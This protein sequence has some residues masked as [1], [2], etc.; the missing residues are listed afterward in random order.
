LFGVCLFSVRLLVGLIGAERARRRGI[1]AAPS[2]VVHMVS[3]LS[4]RLRIRRPVRVVVSALADAPALIGWLRTVILL[5]FSTLN[6]LTP[7]QLEA[8][9]TH[10]LAHIRRHDYLVNLLQTVVETV[11]FY[12]PAVWWISRRLRQEREHCCDDWAVSLCGDRMAYA[13]ALATLEGLRAVRPKLAVAVQGGSLTAR[14]RRIVGTPDAT[15]SPKA[16]LALVTV[17]FLALVAQLSHNENS[18]SA[19]DAPIRESIATLPLLASSEI[20]HSAAPS[21]LDWPQWLGSPEKNSAVAGRN[22]PIDWDVGT[23]QNIRWNAR[24][25][26]QT[27]GSPVVSGG[28]VFIGTNNGAAHLKRYP[29]T[30]D[31]GCLL[32]FDIETGAFLWQHSTEKHPLGRLVDWE[33]IGICSTPVV[34]GDRL[35]Y[36]TNRCE[37]VCLDT[38]GFRDGENDGPYR[39]EPNTNIDEA[40]IV[41][42]LD[43]ISVLNVLPH[44]ASNCSPVVVGDLLFIGTSNGFDPARR[45]AEQPAGAPSFVCLDRH[46]GKLLWS[47]NSPG[48]NILHGQWSSPAFGIFGGVAQVIFGGGDGWLYSFA[49]TGEHGRSKLL[50]KFDCNPKTSTYL[51]AR[52]TRLPVVAT[53][54][55]YDGLVYVAVGDDPE[56]GEG[57]GRLWCIDPNRRGDVSQTLVFNR[58]NPHVPIAHKRLCACEPEQGDFERPNPNS[59]LV[60]KYEGSDTSRFES[61]LHRTLSSAAIRDGLLFLADQSGLLHCLD[62]KTGN[63]HWTHDLLAVAWSTP[64]IVG[65]RV[66][67]CDNDG[68]VSIFRLSSDKQ[69]L[70]EQSVGAAMYSSPGIA[71]DVLYFA[72]EGRLLAVASAATPEKPSPTVDGAP[73]NPEN[74]ASRDRLVAKSHRIRFDAGRVEYRENEKEKTVDFPGELLLADNVR[75]TVLT[76]D[77]DNLRM[78]SDRALVRC[79][80]LSEEERRSRSFAFDKLELGIHGNVRFWRESK[81]A[82]ERISFSAKSLML[83]LPVPRFEANGVGWQMTQREDS[84]NSETNF[85]TK[86]SDQSAVSGESTK[87]T[88]IAQRDKERTDKPWSVHG[89]V[90]DADGKPMPGVVVRAH[91]GIGTLRGGGQATTDAEGKYAFSF[92]PGIRFANNDVQLQAAT[93]APHK[94]GFFEKNLS[95]QGDLVAALKMPEGEIGWGGKTKDDVILPGKP[96]ELNFVMLPAAKVSG[97]LIDKDAKP[98]AGYGVSLT[99]RNLYPSS[100]VMASTKTDDAGRFTLADIPTGFSYQFLVE[101]AKRE[102]PWNAW[103]S[104]PYEFKA[105]GRDDL[106]I[107]RKENELEA[108]RFEIQV[109]GTGVNWKEA[110]RTGTSFQNLTLPGDTLSTDARVHAAVARLVL[111]PSAPAKPITKADAAQ[112]A[113]AA[114]SKTNLTRTQPDADGKFTLTFDNPI[115]RRANARMQL[116]PEKHQV[117]FQ[118]FVRNAE[119]KLQEKIFKQLPARP[120]G[121]YHVNVQV[122][123]DL[124][125]HSSVSITFVTIQ[126][127][128]DRW[129]KAFF[130]D[131]KGTS[132]SGMWSSDGGKLI[133]VAVDDKTQGWS[134]DS[135]QQDQSRLSSGDHSI[136]V[137]GTVTDTSGRAIS[138]AVV[139][140]PFSNPLRRS[141]SPATAMVKTG[142]GGQFLLVQPED[143][144]VVPAGRPPA[145]WCWARGYELKVIPLDVRRIGETAITLDPETPISFSVRN[146]EGEAVAGATVAP[147]A[148]AFPHRT[149]EPHSVIEYRHFPD[150]MLPLLATTTDA[151][152]NGRLTGVSWR[153][154]AS[155]LVQSPAIGKHASPIALTAP[156][157]AARLIVPLPARISGRITGDTRS[158]L[159]NIRIKAHFVSPGVQNSGGSSLS[160]EQVALTDETGRFEFPAIAPGIVQIGAVLEPEGAFWARHAIVHAL[161]PGEHVT[162]DF[163]LEVPVTVTGTVINRATFRPVPDFELTVRSQEGSGF[164]TV[165][166]D[167]EGRFSA[168]VLSGKFRIVPGSGEWHLD[169][170]AQNLMA[171]PDDRPTELPPFLVDEVVQNVGRVVDKNLNPVEHI[172]VSAISY[173]SKPANLGGGLTDRNGA[174]TIRLPKSQPIF[175]YEAFGDYGR[176]IGDVEVA[177]RDPLVLKLNAWPD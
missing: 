105:G 17:L 166:T 44:N 152:G 156:A 18:A 154:L 4:E 33:K 13:R 48:E 53:P 121:G 119:G 165:R 56:H 173:G 82:E 131:G 84:K 51:L 139:F 90:T 108:T 5:P 32:C 76:P 57:P 175:R 87:Q 62:A 123:P 171:K 75:M 130:H 140:L 134:V 161:K 16:A 95:R 40:D 14:I 128:H 106:F 74:A 129:V 101:P 109:V 66:Y 15:A 116:D 120:N 49:P 69:L 112:L 126:P 58:Q 7:D 24:L 143:W 92:G 55:I 158:T 60:W 135:S 127:E 43:L 28:K 8:I 6:G 170:V 137:A 157:D 147:R 102:P 36:V 86:A 20:P 11:L 133:G 96:R 85:S 70:A 136:T 163:L 148:Y 104:G 80:L 27:Y 29:A 141:E 98:L 37:I 122:P 1:S 151:D 91:T 155:A 99:G 38:A 19:T 79:Q 100:S 174:F 94:D 77:G 117:I 23:G 67:V 138:E 42:K 22:V 45:L 132:Y 125:E 124:I 54:V 111:D 68:D 114:T 107:Q 149:R 21:P 61:T 64:L 118:V 52:G 177:Q 89:R 164:D 110:L 73:Q 142:K 59:A 159:N 150:E 113:D 41:W 153:D 160:G 83:S 12:H 10:E 34:V 47:D 167:A 97:T 93:I 81:D 31:L 65:D 25:G 115:P 146:S 46:T 9:L 35:W 63:C 2:T 50:W 145:I 3:R 78:M 144:L 172:S 88:E 168:K 71:D 103:A 176:K 162:L 30:T 39:D 169:S 26:S 72:A